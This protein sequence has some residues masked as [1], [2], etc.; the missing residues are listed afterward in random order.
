MH[1]DHKTIR[2][3]GRHECERGYEQSGTDCAQGITP[4]CP[5]DKRSDLELK[6]RI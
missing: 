5:F 2:V 3:V 6:N 4:S 1:L